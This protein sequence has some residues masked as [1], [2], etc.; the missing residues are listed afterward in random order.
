MHIFVPQAIGAIDISVSFHCV[1][2]S[3]R[4]QVHDVG[5]R[6]GHRF[7]PKGDFIER[8]EG[9]ERREAIPIEII[10]PRLGYSSSGRSADLG[11]GIGYFSFPLAELAAEVVAIDIEQKMLGVIAGRASER[12]VD[13]IR[14]VQG[15]I[16]S[17]PFA[18]SSMDHILTAFVYHEVN[19]QKRL[20]A[21]CAR[22]LR[23]NGHLD[24]ID[25]QKRETS[26]GPPLSERKPPQHVVRSA[27]RLYELESR[28]ET[29]VFYLL[30]FSKK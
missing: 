3:G 8:L 17:L 27:A 14:L 11:A 9:K 24:I 4:G 2:L 22:V 1:L 20:L 28:F 19:S 6:E 7:E 12:G 18:D 26:I 29:G 15:E 21:E 23:K 30:G 10:V 25:F 5:H 16:T 13:N